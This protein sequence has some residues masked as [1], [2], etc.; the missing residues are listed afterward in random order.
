MFTVF[1]KILKKEKIVDEDIEK[2]NDFVFIQML[3]GDRVGVQIAQVL[4]R[5]YSIPIRQKVQLTQSIL[6][7]EITY[8]KYPKKDKE[9]DEYVSLLQKTY[10]LSQSEAKTYYDILS[11]SDLEELKES[12]KIGGFKR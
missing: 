4:N 3:S 1:K 6:P 9:K 8:I 10:N 2:I 11:T 5:Y 12:L 7:K